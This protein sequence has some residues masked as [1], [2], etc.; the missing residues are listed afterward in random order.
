MSVLLTIFETKSFWIAAFFIGWIAAGFWLG[1]I[2][3]RRLKRAQDSQSY[4]LPS[5][6]LRRDDDRLTS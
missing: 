5:G 4:P 1:P 2:I 6:S 3:G